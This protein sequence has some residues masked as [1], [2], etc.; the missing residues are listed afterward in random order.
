MGLS[1]CG[2]FWILAQIPVSLLLYLDNLK[3]H[4]TALKGNDL[5][6]QIIN[7]FM[8]DFLPNIDIV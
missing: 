1:K 6:C 5:F 3:C 2:M 7:S 8:P 4:V